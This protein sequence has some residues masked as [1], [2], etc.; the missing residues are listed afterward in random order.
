M[1]IKNKYRQ[2]LS[3]TGERCN[4]ELRILTRNLC[5]I[6]KEILRKRIYNPKRWLPPNNGKGCLNSCR[7]LARQIP[8]PRFDIHSIR[9]SCKLGR[10]PSIPATSTTGSQCGN[11]TKK[12]YRPQS[13]INFTHISFQSFI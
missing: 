12:T 1:L 5:T 9:N 6:K 7:S 8:I 4:L 10:I 2:V 11:N 3:T 13:E